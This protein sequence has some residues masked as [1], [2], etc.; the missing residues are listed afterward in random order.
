[1]NSKTNII[2][3]V[4]N[5]KLE[6][7]QDLHSELM[8][9]AAIITCRTSNQ[10]IIPEAM[11]LTEMEEKSNYTQFILEHQLDTYDRLLMIIA[12]AP[13]VFPS[14]FKDFFPE[15]QAPRPIQFKEGGAI[16]K[17]GRS[18]V[19]SI[20]TFLYLACGNDIKMR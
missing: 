4:Q 17:S 10:D 3:V 8:W 11:V 13:H 7:R 1:M 19:P 9:L 20:E 5:P 16:S 15:N 14:V 2:T 18:F 12:V 6:L